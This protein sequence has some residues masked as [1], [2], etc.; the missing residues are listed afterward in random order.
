[1]D[2]YRAV[3]TS[4]SGVVLPYWITTAF[5]VSQ[6]FDCSCCWLLCF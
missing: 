3:K 1:M 6:R 5:S 4:R 2:M